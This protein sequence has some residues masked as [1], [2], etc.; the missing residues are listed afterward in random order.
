MVVGTREGEWLFDS[1]IG[2]G[3]GEELWVELIMREVGRDGGG[4]LNFGCCHVALSEVNRFGW[5]REDTKGGF[6][7]NLAFWRTG[8]IPLLTK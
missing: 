8:N 4:D 5:D 2:E 6:P 1:G 3:V 7:F